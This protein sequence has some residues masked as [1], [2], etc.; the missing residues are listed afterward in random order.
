EPPARRVATIIAHPGAVG[1]RGGRKAQVALSPRWAD[2]L[3]GQS[4]LAARRRWR[5][6]GLDQAGQRR[7]A[8]E[9]VQ[10]NLPLL[11][12]DG[13]LRADQ[14][15]LGLFHSRMSARERDQ[16]CP[17]YGPPTDIAGSDLGALRL[18]ESMS[19][20]FVNHGLALSFPGEPTR[21]M[22]VWIACIR[23]V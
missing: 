9:V 22:P 10:G 14:D 3:A 15:C 1:E 4:H 18:S 6:G 5:A 8:L 12:P 11:D 20:I 7:F 2:T 21:H 16:R 13:A 23:L 17:G 19:Q